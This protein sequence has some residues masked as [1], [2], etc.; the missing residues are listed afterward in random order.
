MIELIGL[1]KFT[2]QVYRALLRNRTWGIAEMARHFGVSDARIRGSLDTLAELSLVENTSDYGSGYDIPNPEIG[3]SRA[4][5]RHDLDLLERHRKI[6]EACIAVARLSLA[7]E[8]THGNIIAEHL[9]GQATTR[10][11]LMALLGDA[12]SDYQSLV[13]MEGQVAQDLAAAL[14]LDQLAVERGVAVRCV[15][16]DS[17]RNNRAILKEMHRIISIGGQVRTA[18]TLPMPVVIID[19]EIVLVPDELARDRGS[20]LQVSSPAIVAGF[21]ALFDRI[22][23]SASTAG[24][25]VTADQAGLTPFERQLLDLLSEGCTDQRAAHQLGVSL[26]TIRRTMSDLKERMGA[27]SRFEAGVRVARNGWLQ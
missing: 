9:R 2:E 8:E 23:K 4:L 13:P 19:R 26:R 5:E 14:P 6:R 25:P 24:Q 20:A 17:V 27:E 7:Y 15:Y 10:H 21:V 11:R 3:L 22:W 1:D 18:P 16:Q 12:Q